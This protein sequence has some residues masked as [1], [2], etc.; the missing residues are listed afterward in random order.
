M[1]SDDKNFM[2]LSEG[3]RHFLMSLP[4]K[5][6]NR[7]LTRSKSLFIPFIKSWPS[8]Q[9]SLHFVFFDTFPWLIALLH[10]HSLALAGRSKDC[11]SHWPESEK[12]LIYIFRLPRK[13]EN[14]QYEN[15]QYE[16]R[17]SIWLS[18]QNKNLLY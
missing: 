8:R 1:I 3:E 12:W 17:R 15:A 4:P 14:H 2:I 13:L 18:P 6:K 5:I 10:V 9:L 11:R 16:N 7:P